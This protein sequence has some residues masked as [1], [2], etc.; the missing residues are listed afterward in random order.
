MAYGRIS[1]TEFDKENMLDSSNKQIQEM[2]CL[3]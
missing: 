2:I 1:D 3:K